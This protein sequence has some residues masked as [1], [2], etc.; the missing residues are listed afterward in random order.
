[1]DLDF[2]AG[3]GLVLLGCGK[4]GTAMLP[5][6]ALYGAFASLLLIGGYFL[7]DLSL[8]L[9]LI[10]LAGLIVLVV[11]YSVFMVMRAAYSRL[12]LD[13]SNA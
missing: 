12:G 8:Y 7:S 5:F 3:R 13:L 11:G 6:Y 9:S 4:M 1:M 2:I 10:D